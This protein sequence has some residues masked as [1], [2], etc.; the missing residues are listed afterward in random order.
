MKIFV[1]RKE[2]LCYN[3]FTELILGG[4]NVKESEVKSIL[5]EVI[6]ILEPLSHED[7]KQALALLQGMVIGKEL[8]EQ[9]K[10]A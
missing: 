8:A 4:D 2:A 10:T 9:Q 1:D 6:A 5:A 3:K 7:K